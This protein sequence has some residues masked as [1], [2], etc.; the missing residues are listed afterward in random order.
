V[1]N[2]YKTTEAKIPINTL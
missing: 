2:A 1:K